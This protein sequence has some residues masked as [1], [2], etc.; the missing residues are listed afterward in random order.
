MALLRLIGRRHS[1]VPAPAVLTKVGTDGTPPVL[2]YVPPQQRPAIE[3][4][5]HLSCSAKAIAALRPSDVDEHGIRIAGRRV[6][7]P[8]SVP[9]ALRDLVINLA[10]A[11]PHRSRLFES[12]KP[13][14]R[15]AAD[16]RSGVV[17]ALAGPERRARLA[18]RNLDGVRLPEFLVLGVPRSATT[19]LY[20][21]LSRHPEI[22]L[23]PTKEQEFFGDYLYHFGLNAYLEHFA[24]R[25][26]QRVAGDVSVGYFHAPEAPQQIIDT[27]GPRAKLI[28]V[29]RE[30]IERAKSYYHFRLLSGMMP[31]TF[32]DAVSLPYF[33]NLF[34]EQGHYARY[35]TAWYRHFAQKQVLLLLYEDVVRDPEAV[36]STVCRFLEV[37]PKLA[38]PPA[39]NSG[40][41]ITGIPLHRWL[42]RTAANLDV[43]PYPATRIGQLVSRRLRRL[44]AA[45]CL[46][47]AD[48]HYRVMLRSETT[49]SLQGIFAPSNEALARLT[50]LDLGAWRYAPTAQPLSSLATMARPI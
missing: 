28:V 39:V 45:V 4:A 48:Q 19:W 35:L 10:R 20:T 31:G 13:L 30:P 21:A 24:A 11:T 32:E 22:Y 44:D 17:R 33:R 27:L 3:L 1:W 2:S 15:A 18:Q 29:L 14:R 9:T 42:C 23:P 16:L 5:A 47:A 50:G 38:A 46:H 25:T 43:L 49:T 40:A 7:W 26:D 6:V 37:D 36:L 12:Q 41:A 8:P 34:I